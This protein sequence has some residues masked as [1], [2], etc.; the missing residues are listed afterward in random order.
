MSTRPRF[1]DT[2]GTLRW[3]DELGKYEATSG[4]HGIALDD[5]EYVDPGFGAQVRASGT[6]SEIAPDVYV[7]GAL[8]D[9]WSQNIQDWRL[10]VLAPT[11][12]DKAG[13]GQWLRADNSAGRY[14]NLKVAPGGAPIEVDVKFIP[15]GTFKCQ[16]TSSVAYITEEDLRVAQTVFGIDVAMHKL[17]AQMEM[18]KTKRGMDTY[19]VFLNL[20]ANLDPIVGAGYYASTDLVVDSWDAWDVDGTNPFLQIIDAEKLILAAGAVPTANTL[21]VSK[22]GADYLRENSTWK[23]EYSLTIDQQDVVIKPRNGKARRLNLVI[24]DAK[25]ENADGTL[26]EAWGNNAWIGYLDSAYK[27]STL[28]PVL[29]AVVGDDTPRAWIFPD[30]NEAVAKDHAAVRGPAYDVFVTSESGINCGVLIRNIYT[31]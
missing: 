29:T 20:D 31:V 19:R 14:L 24:C 15:A 5:L 27:P 18:H 1:T 22:I 6:L 4:K 11:Y 16:A 10:D 7:P 26:S 28:T 25:I 30:S 23:G 21:I 3:S 13:Y 8:A 12:Q 9:Q 17:N 2:Y